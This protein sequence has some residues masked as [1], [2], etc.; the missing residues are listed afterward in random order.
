MSARKRR[1][2]KTFRAEKE[3]RRLARRRLGVPPAGH[4]IESAKLKPPKH[5][6]LAREQELNEL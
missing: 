1:K 6:K 3:V 2:R 5:K 4:R